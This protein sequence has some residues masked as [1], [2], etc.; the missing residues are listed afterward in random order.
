MCKLTETDEAITGDALVAILQPDLKEMG[1]ASLGHRLTIL[2][3]IYDLK[4]R[5]NVAI[6][7]DHFIP[8]CTSLKSHSRSVY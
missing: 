6:E 1:V 7:P 5:Q 8:L 4:K 3:G 2:K